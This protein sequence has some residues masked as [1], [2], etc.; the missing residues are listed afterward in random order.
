MYYGHF[1]P[2]I[3][4]SLLISSSSFDTSTSTRFLCGTDSPTSAYRLI[5]SI[6]DLFI[7]FRGVDECENFA[8]FLLVQ[9]Q[10]TLFYEQWIAPDWL[11]YLNLEICLGIYTS[12]RCKCFS[13][14]QLWFLSYQRN[15][16][17]TQDL[18]T[19]V[20]SIVALIYF[21]LPWTMRMLFQISLLETWTGS[22][23]CFEY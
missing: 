15:N 17:T 8:L 12:R 13:L 18:Y 20:L 7:C 23:Y 22:G 5:S 11:M 19:A 10:S 4:C 1:R 3:C 14:H 6:V 2:C 16:N 9:Y 21:L